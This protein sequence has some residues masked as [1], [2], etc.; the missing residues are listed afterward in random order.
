MGLVQ[1][2]L[3]GFLERL[4]ALCGEFEGLGGGERAVQRLVQVH[5]LDEMNSIDVALL[6]Y[7]VG[8]L[9]LGARNPSLELGALCGAPI[10]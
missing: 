2:S 1:E 6:W 9:F 3:V 8:Q 10:T 4:E 7:V 5:I